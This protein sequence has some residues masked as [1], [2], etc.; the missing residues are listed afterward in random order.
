MKKSILAALFALLLHFPDTGQASKDEKQYMFFGQEYKP[1]S[2]AEDGRLMGG[3]VQVVKRVCGKMNIK[4]KFESVPIKRQIQ[5]LESGLT[6]GVLN[7]IPNSD[8][9]AYSTLSIPVIQSNMSYFAVKGTFKPIKSLEELNGATVGAL[10]ASSAEKIALTHK[11]QIK[12]LKV[13]SESE[14]LTVLNKLTAGRYGP[15]G[16]AISNE[17]VFTTLIKELKINNL[18]VVY[19]AETYGFR[20]AFSKKAVDAEF[21]KLFN[22][23]IAKMKQSG[24]LKKLLKPFGLKPAR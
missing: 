20:V 24:E 12:E 22:S 2:W 6:D 18:E 21:I 15:K 19:V 8:R 16:L 5:M 10:A 23:N 9:D 13:E 3:M 14:I 1:F 4:C 11:D 7:F 17:D